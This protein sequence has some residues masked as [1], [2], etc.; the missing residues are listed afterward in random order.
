MQQKIEHLKH[1]LSITPP[2]TKRYVE[3]LGHL[4]DWYESKFRISDNISDLEEVIKYGR[5][6]LD[7]TPVGTPWR[8]NPLAS[9]HRIHLLAFEKAGKIGYLDESITIGYD[10]LELKSAAYFHFHVIQ[11]PV[12]SLLTREQLLGRIED[13][14]EAIRLISSGINDQYVQYPDRF[15]LSC[16][17]AILARRIGH[18][19]TLAA[20]KTAM[21]LMQK[22]FS[23]A[24]TVSVQHTR[25]VAMGKNCQT[26]PLDYASYQIRPGQFEEAVETL[27]QGRALLWSEMR[28]FRTPAIQVIE[29]D[30]PLAKRFAEINQELETL[31]ISV[32]PSGRPDVEDGVQREKDGTDPFGRLLIKRKKLVGERDALILQI[33]GQ[34]GLEGFWGHHCSTLSVLLP[35]VA[36]SLLSTTANGALISS[37]SSTILSLAPFLPL[38][39]SSLTQTNYRKS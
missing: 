8:N 35:P 5:Q 9:L 10:I 28:G 29:D 16:Q 14:F 39:H 30:S 33:Q 34:P 26:M 38:K 22:S 13:F 1:L 27:E 36:Q 18:S 31:T 15:R 7:A 19:T 37:L 32:T 24:P 11:R 12:L 4:E 3:C 2:G 21:S 20:Y 17:W 23:F 6:A 25:L